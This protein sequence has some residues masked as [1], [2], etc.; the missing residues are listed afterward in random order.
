MSVLLTK[1]GLAGLQVDMYNHAEDCSPQMLILQLCHE[2]LTCH[3]STLQ[4]L[5]TAV[6][7]AASL[8]VSDVSIDTSGVSSHVKDLVSDGRS[9][10]IV[11]VFASVL[12]MV[13]EGTLILIRFLNFGVVNRFFGCFTF[14]VSGIITTY[15]MPA[16]YLEPKL[17]KFTLSG[18]AC[19]L[20]LSS[21][22]DV[23]TAIVVGVLYLA[24]AVALGVNLNAWH[25]Q[26][27]YWEQQGA[28][29]NS[30]SQRILIDLAI[31][32]VCY[33]GTVCPCF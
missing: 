33:F 21:T 1:V 31:T 7:V 26:M 19:D 28:T 20:C 8:S 11:M 29:L 14:R 16:K 32:I 9:A 30:R 5:S 10:A 6:L 3:F 4:V 15:L 27:G 17:C 12:A 18:S 23:L 2:H 22:Q 13:I 25:Q 24:G